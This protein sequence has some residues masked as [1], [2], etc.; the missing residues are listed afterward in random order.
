MNRVAEVCAELALYRVMI[1]ID[2]IVDH[3]STEATIE[4][5]ACLWTMLHDM[6]RSDYISK[7]AGR[8]HRMA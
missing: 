6:Q 1:G 5:E 7:E 2:E 8:G 3:Y 4:M